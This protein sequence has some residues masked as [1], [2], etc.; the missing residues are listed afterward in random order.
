M[1]EYYKRSLGDLLLF[2]F[3]YQN[4]QNLELNCD[5]F[6][7]RTVHGQRTGPGWITPNTLIRAGPAGQLP[8]LAEIW[9]VPHVSGI[10][11]NGFNF[12]KNKSEFSGN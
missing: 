12:L 6:Q 7:E 9:G 3:A 4:L 11:K 2:C 8:W 5:S 1:T 10:D